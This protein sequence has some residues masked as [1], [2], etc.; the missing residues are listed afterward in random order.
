MQLFDR[1]GKCHAV[2]PAPQRGSL[3]NVEFGGPDGD[4]L[5]ATNGDK[6]FKRETKVRG[7]VPWRAPMKPPLPR[8]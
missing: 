8:L 7:V 1:I 6:G 3:S 2:I 5:Y 4:D